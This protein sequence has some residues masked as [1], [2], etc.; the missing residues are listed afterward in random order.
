MIC[1]GILED[2][3]AQR[4]LLW[5]YLEK[6]SEERGARMN[7]EVFGDSRTFL[8]NAVQY[9]ILLLDIFLG[10]GQPTGFE[11]AQRVRERDQDVMVL[12]IT[13]LAHFALRGY[14]VNAFDFI[15]K[16]VSYPA[17]REKMG[18]ALDRLEAS[19]E[20]K[21]T[22]RTRGGLTRLST[23]AILFVEVR[24]HSITFHTRDGLVETG[25]AM[26]KVEAMLEGEDFFRCHVAYLVNLRQVDAVDRAGAV[27]GGETVPISR[28]RRKAFMQALVDCLGGE[29]L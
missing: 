23:G 3:A 13:N 7:V 10:E 1:I 16:P 15:I 25:G 6:L 12:F 4:Q 27:V 19:K 11:V 29:L 14:S 5:D 28:H 17:F 8:E 24:G 9:D 21:L 18:R 2:E 22:L 26:S 20:K